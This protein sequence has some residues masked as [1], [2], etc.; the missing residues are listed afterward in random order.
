MRYYVLMSKMRLYVVLVRDFSSF[1][2]AFLTQNLFSVTY[3]LSANAVCKNADIF[4]DEFFSLLT[5]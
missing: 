3:E 2:V 5:F 4:S 1:T